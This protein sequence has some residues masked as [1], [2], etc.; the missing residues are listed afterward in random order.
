MMKGITKDIT[1]VV[2][3]PNHCLRLLF[4]SPRSTFIKTNS[5]IITMFFM[6]EC[7]GFMLIISP[8]QWQFSSPLSK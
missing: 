5:M 8:M 6:M 1:N 7:P 4:L 3:A 2:P